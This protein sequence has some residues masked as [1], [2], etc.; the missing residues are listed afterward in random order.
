MSLMRV[1][2]SDSYPACGVRST[3][4]ATSKSN[5]DPLT[6]PAD[7]STHPSLTSALAATSDCTT[8]QCWFRIASDRHDTPAPSNTPLWSRYLGALDTSEPAWRRGE[9]RR[10]GRRWGEERARR[11]CGRR[12]HGSRGA[13]ALGERPHARPSRTNS[14]LP[15]AAANHS[16]HPDPAVWCP[17]LPPPN[18]YQ[19]DTHSPSH[20]HFQYPLTSASPTADGSPKRLN[21]SELYETDVRRVGFWR[22]SAG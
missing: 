2:R 12:Q 17:D 13:M 18:P 11:A 8:P 20:T 21:T 15:D 14:S 1:L 19:S 22:S 16:M 5:A 4:H 7:P 3:L 10:D 6:A 9:G